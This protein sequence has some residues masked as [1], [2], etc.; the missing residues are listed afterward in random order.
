MSLPTALRVAERELMGNYAALWPLTKILD[1]GGTERS[2]HLTTE[3]HETGDL[4]FQYFL[5]NDEND[6]FLFLVFLWN[7]KFRIKYM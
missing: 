7:A 5:Q 2:P 4:D 3:D 6:H 1:I